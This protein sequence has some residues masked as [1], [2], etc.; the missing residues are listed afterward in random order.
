MGKVLLIGGIG[1]G[2]TSLKQKLLNQ[3]INY[4][5]T[6]V[7]EFSECFIDCPGEYLEIPQ[8]YHILIDINHRVS[9]IWALQDAGRNRCF[10]PPNF[11]RVFTRPV[12]GVI[13][14][15]DLPQAN[16]QKA[17]S[18]LANAGVTGEIYLTSALSGEGC[19]DLISRLE[20]LHESNSNTL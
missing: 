18:L 1:T 15:V 7:L 20:A 4:R 12:I 2:K 3:E 8:Y 10:Y 17:R 6:Q 19:R 14:K 16:V 5:K 13:T 11:T 9:E